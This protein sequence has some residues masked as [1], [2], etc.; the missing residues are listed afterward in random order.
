VGQV[1]SAF[2][3]VSSV[4]RKPIGTIGGDRDTRKLFG[5]ALVEAATV[6]TAKG[7]GSRRASSGLASSC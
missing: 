1:L 6:A 2:G 4:I 3:G 7:I 5:E